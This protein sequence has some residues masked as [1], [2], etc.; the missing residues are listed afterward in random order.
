[1]TL[2]RIG[3]VGSGPVA[4]SLAWALAGAGYVICG[5]TS[6]SPVTRRMLAESAG[7][8]EVASAQQVV[9][10]AELTF[11]CT[12]DDAIAPVVAAIRWPPSAVVHCSG[13]LSLE[14]LRPAERAGVATGSFHPLQVF[15]KSRPLTPV[16]GIT[17]GIECSDTLWPELEALARRIGCLP[18]RLRAEDKA[19]YHLAGV[20]ASNYVVAVAAVAA[21]LWGLIGLDRDTAV[22]ALVPLLSAAVE[23]IGSHGLS[24]G[25]TGPVARGDLGTLRRHLRTLQQ[26]SPENVALYRELALR[27]LPLVQDA[28]GD[29]QPVL[30]LLQSEVLASASAA[31][32]QPVATP[33]PELGTMA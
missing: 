16:K 11:I 31:I 7:A 5:V 6:R 10:A 15:P 8:P 32:A 33:Q 27:L 14:P 18:V 28:G 23:A 29:I 30:A 13:A 1:M 17:A 20:F 26:R 2:T 19:L 12:P 3:F 25:L 9:D 4:R 22:N 24:G 21:E